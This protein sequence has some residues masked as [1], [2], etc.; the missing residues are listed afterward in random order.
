M[1]KFSF[2]EITHLS[3]AVCDK[4]DWMVQNDKQH[5]ARYKAFIDLRDKLAFVSMAMY[6]S[7]DYD[8]VHISPS[9]YGYAKPLPT[10]GE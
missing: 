9:I 10:K 3:D 7:K 1:E 8:V 5:T 2:D 4:L 6:E